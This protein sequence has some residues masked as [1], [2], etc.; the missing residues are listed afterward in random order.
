M[1]RTKQD[2]EAVARQVC[3]A[4]AAGE[5][6]G[7]QVGRIHFELSEIA[8]C[9]E[10]VRECCEAAAGTADHGPLS[11]KYFGGTARETEA[12]LRR[13]GAEIKRAEA[14]PGDIVCFNRNA[15][16]WGHI[17]V[18]LGGTDFAEN[19]SSR[20]RGPGF[21]ISRFAQ[22]ETGPRGEH[23][24][25]I[26]G[27]YSIFPEAPVPQWIARKVVLLPGWERSATPIMVDDQHW[28]KVREVAEMF[29]CELVDKRTEDGKLYLVRRR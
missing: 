16:Q 25:R 20:G 21:V 15:C 27:F 18:G 9:S 6:G 23:R 14:L 3:A 17:G 24:P 2:V 13:A 29:D 7:M 22:I 10:F 26:S 1:S 8:R 12:K 5:R 19:T 4:Y 11:T 28:L